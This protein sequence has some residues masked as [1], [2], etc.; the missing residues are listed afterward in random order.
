MEKIPIDNLPEIILSSSQPRTS[1]MISRAV[2]AGKLRKLAPKI[3]SSNL[4]DPPEIII[5]RNRYFILGQLFPNAVISHRSALEGG[6]ANN[7]VVLTYKYTKNIKLPG[8]QIRLHQGP[9]PDRDDT[10]FLENLFIASQARAFLENMQTSRSRS[11]LAK[12]LSKIQIESR[13]DRLAHIYGETE[14]N[15]LRDKAKQTAKRLAMT[16][17]FKSLEQM[18][19]ALLGTRQTVK[20]HSEPGRAR[21]IGQP[22][23]THRIDLFASL[24]AYL[25]Q[26]LFELHS[27]PATNATARKNLAFFEAYFSNFIE[28]TEFAIEEAK[29]IVFENKINANRPEDS[30]DILSTFRIVSNQQIMQQTPIDAE[31]LLNQ[32]QRLHLQLMEQRPA[33]MPG[34]FKDKEN[35]AGNTVFVKPTEVKGTLIKG[36]EFYQHLQ[37]GMARACFMMFLIS[38]VHPFTDGNGRLARIMMNIELEANHQSRIIIPTV[39]REDYLLALRR[40]SRQQDPAPYT[41]M[42]ARAQDFTSRVDYSSYPKCLAQMSAANAF[43][44]PNEGKLILPPKR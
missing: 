43:M 41:K 23:D 18:I 9:G 20:L 32:L 5:T 38:E 33:A 19:S 3:Y 7:M 14:L 39:Y 6:V 2:R 1:Q 13:L 37:G 11:T 40:L 16:E 27:S 22:F 12:T 34:K 35:R 31:T 36:F 42:L 30:H 17:Q 4:I 15:K 28:G 10:P 26:Y 25:Q 21:A 24:A 44:E 8:L 29:T